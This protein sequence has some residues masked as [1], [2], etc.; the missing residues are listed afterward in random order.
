M[1]HDAPPPLTRLFHGVLLI[2][3][4]VVLLWWALQI[5]AEIWGWLLLIALS[6]AAA[7]VFIRWRRSRR[8]RW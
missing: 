5:L 8:D 7:S 6:V 3:V 4:V 1:S 2:C